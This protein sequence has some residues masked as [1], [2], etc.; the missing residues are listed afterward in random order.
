LGTSRRDTGT[1]YTPQSLTAPVVQTAL[2]PLV[3]RCEEGKPGKLVEPREVRRPRELLALRVCDPAM[4]SGA[5]LVQVV[6]YLADRLV[7]AWDREVARHP[8]GTVLGLPFAEP[9][10]DAEGQ[11]VLRP[12]D[13]AGMVLAA[14][15][16]VVERSVYGVDVNPLA[17]E[18]GKLSLWLATLSRDRPFTFLDHALKCGDSLLGADLDQL[19]TWSWDRT[20][21]GA[22]FLERFLDQAVDDALAPRRELEELG[23]G[24]GGATKARL[25]AKAEAAVVR[26]RVAADLLMGAWIGGATP[27]ER[28]GLRERLGVLVSAAATSE[29]WEVLR[30]RSGELL[31]GRR[32]L[33][34]PLEYPEILVDRGGFD[35][36]VGNPPFVGGKK[37]TGNLGVPY[38]EWLVEVLANGCRGHADLVAYFFLRGL[39]LVR[40]GGGYAFVAVDTLAQGDTRE[41]G[42]DQ[43]VAAG[44]TIRNAN[45]A[46][47]WPGRAGIRIVTV[48]TW[49]G[50]YRGPHLLDGE[51]VSTITTIL[52]ASEVV[53]MPFRLKANEPYNYQ[54]SVVL[55]MG[56]VLA[57][58]AAERLLAAHPRNAEVIQ[59]YVNGEDVNTHPGQ[60]STR[61]VINFR[62]WTEEKARSWPDVFAVIE[63]DVKPERTRR[64]PDG[65]FKLREPLPT[66]WWHYADK[67]PAL[68]RALA[69]LR[70][71][72]V[73]SRVSKYFVPAWSPTGRVFSERLVVFPF[74]DDW[75]FSVL[76]STFHDAW[77]TRYMSTFESRPMYAP[78]DCFE[79]FPLP[80]DTSPLDAIGERYHE[81]RRQLMLARQIGLTKT[82][83]LFHGKPNEDEDI[84]TLRALHVELD[85]A[86]RDAYGWFDLD[87]GLGWQKTTR[88]VERKDRKTGNTV[89]VEEVDWRYTISPAARDELLRRLLALNHQRYAEEVAAG[90]HDAKKGKK[91][92]EEE[93]PTD[94]P[95]PPTKPKR[96]RPPEPA[97][98][99]LF[100]LPEDR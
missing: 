29:D 66:R 71:A 82:Y 58:E 86:V 68:Y 69:P 46:R 80:L 28:E 83:N 53:G 100:R 18:M 11:A 12:E 57:Q 24:E 14:R 99:T 91:E 27:K 16:L 45:T 38:R 22:A 76:Q 9:A 32:P 95:S 15:R 49:R 21:S 7:E 97:G 90:L 23:E 72:L 81:H 67:R 40:E 74:A 75:A 56:F 17:V 41:V 44:A 96:R 5:F 60:S 78:E 36:L 2:E 42:L 6:R 52:D 94:G 84:A 93:A 61:W 43:V 26:A 35:A 55:G 64:K 88:A 3:Y 37:I 20:G 87:L 63:A 13:R 19:R 10:A 73:M 30:R 77:A 59:P 1:Q 39:R 25:L 70:R 89:T 4:G 8:E 47:D 34:W 50:L 85:I 51:R 79:T 62:D 98:P 31:G 48:C 33:H 65:S 92:A 54:G